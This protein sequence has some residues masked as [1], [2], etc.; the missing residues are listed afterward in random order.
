MLK[1]HLYICFFSG[2]ITFLLITFILFSVLSF[3]IVYFCLMSLL[4]LRFCIFAV[5]FEWFS[6][7]IINFIY[8]LLSL[9]LTLKDLMVRKIGLWPCGVAH[10]MNM[11]FQKLRLIERIIVPRF[12]KLFSLLDILK[13]QQRA[14]LSMNTNWLI[15]FG[16]CVCIGILFKVS[17]QLFLSAVRWEIS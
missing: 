17:C 15:S 14:S 2:I 7:M 3:F 12:A 16:Y 10:W 1:D 9:R 8:T 13:V 6:W 11:S 4:L 5:I